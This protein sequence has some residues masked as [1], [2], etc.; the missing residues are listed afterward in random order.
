MTIISWRRGK[1]SDSKLTFGCGANPRTLLALR[2]A[3]RRSRTTPKHGQTTVHPRWEL[4]SERQAFG[5]GCVAFMASTPT[6]P[7]A[8]A[9][10]AVLVFL[11]DKAARPRTRPSSCGGCSS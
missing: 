6:P 9:D 11:I 7:P 10:P 4:L 3:E 2:L 8:P 1:V 5:H